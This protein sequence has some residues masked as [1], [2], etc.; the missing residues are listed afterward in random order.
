MVLRRSARRRQGSGSSER[1]TSCRHD[2]V[3]S[4]YSKIIYVWAHT[5]IVQSGKVCP[6]DKQRCIRP[7]ACTFTVAR[8]WDTGCAP[9]TAKLQHVSVSRI[10]PR[11]THGGAR[12]HIV[13]I[14]CCGTI[15]VPTV[16]F[17]GP[18]TITAAVDSPPTYLGYSLLLKSTLRLEHSSFPRPPGLSIVGNFSS[19]Y[20][21]LLRI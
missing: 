7:R 10:Q 3:G 21:V 16:Y 18:A 1:E 20:V 8:K 5:H 15:L 14:E 4:V 13:L 9:G 6:A 12:E 17:K 19:R 11:T 2:P